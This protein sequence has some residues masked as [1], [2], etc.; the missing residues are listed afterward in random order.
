MGLASGKSSRERGGPVRIQLV[1]SRIPVAMPQLLP[2]VGNLMVRYSAGDI[3]I[4]CS[5]TGSGLGPACPS[6]F[7]HSEAQIIPDNQ[8]TLG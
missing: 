1:S 4:L 6:T 2:V 5:G 3:H 8:T 7:Q